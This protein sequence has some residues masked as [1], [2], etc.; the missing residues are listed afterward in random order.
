MGCNRREA[1]RG[2]ALTADQGPVKSFGEAAL[3]AMPGVIDVARIPTGVAIM[4]EMF[5]QALDALEAI[6]T[7]YDKWEAP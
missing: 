6:K 1:H 5:G 7:S 3:R 4:A 2:G